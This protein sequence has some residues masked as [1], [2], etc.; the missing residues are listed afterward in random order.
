MSGYK[1]SM[2]RVVLISRPIRRQ[3]ALDILKGH[4]QISS[5]SEK[6]FNMSPRCKLSLGN[7]RYVQV[8][9]WKGELRVDIREWDKDLPTKRESVSI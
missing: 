2:T 1:W 8:T 4:I 9:E 3:L 5:F 7:G 6:T